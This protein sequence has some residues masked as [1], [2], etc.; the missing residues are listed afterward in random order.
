ML[1][2]RLQPAVLAVALMFVVLTLVNCG[3][4][5]GGCGHGG[6]SSGDVKEESERKEVKTYVCP[7]HPDI[8]S[9]TPGNCPTCGMPLVEKK[10]TPQKNGHEH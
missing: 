7:M 4:M 1:K 5:G 2:R 9:N 6:H 8:T 3:M 10:D